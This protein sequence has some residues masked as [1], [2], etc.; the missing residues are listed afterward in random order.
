[1]DNDALQTGYPLSSTGIHALMKMHKDP[2]D[3]SNNMEP[4]EKEA[5]AMIPRQNEV[6]LDYDGSVETNTFKQDDHQILQLD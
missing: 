5:M 3:R 4:L 2:K 1:M 6:L